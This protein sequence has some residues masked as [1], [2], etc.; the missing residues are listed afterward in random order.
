MINAAFRLKYVP[1]LW[2]VGEVIMIVKS[3]KP[4]HEASSY[5]FISLLLAISNLFEKLLIKRIKPLIEAINLI[6]SHQFRFRHKHSTI[7]QVHRITNI[8][9]DA[10]EKE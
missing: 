1:R 4:P 6:P 2:K 3:G 7:D 9:E 10:L 8:I 5:R